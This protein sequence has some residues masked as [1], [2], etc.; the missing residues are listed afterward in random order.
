MASDLTYSDLETH[1]PE[2]SRL[3]DGG[4][5]VSLTAREQVVANV[6]IN[7]AELLTNRS[8]WGT[9]APSKSNVA[10]DDLAVLLLA[11]H[12][13]VLWRRS[14][15]SGQAAVGQIQNHGGVGDA[16]I[17]Y[18]AIS[19]RHP[20]DQALRATIPGSALLA[21][22]GSAMEEPEAVLGLMVL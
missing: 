12:W 17:D 13:L 11:G 20:D 6:L 1:V 2:A 14:Q 7:R 8:A 4:A 10:P 5:A 22:R 16:S 9:T 18:R 15:N 3:T 19:D 21:L